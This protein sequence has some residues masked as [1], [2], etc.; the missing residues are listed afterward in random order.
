MVILDHVAWPRAQPLGQS[1]SLK[2]F[3]W[4]LDVSPSLLSL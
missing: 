4:K 1:V 2:F 3:H